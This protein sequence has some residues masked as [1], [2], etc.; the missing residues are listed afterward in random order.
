MMFNYILS[1]IYP[2]RCIFC[3]KPLKIHSE[4]KYI[5]S[6]CA[7]NMPFYSKDISMDD[8]GRG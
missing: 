8:T 1:L 2:E 5:C 3:G 7:E 4:E 6:N